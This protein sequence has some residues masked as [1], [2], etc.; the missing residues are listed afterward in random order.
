MR[1]ALQHTATL[2]GILK[3]EKGSMAT[4]N[5]GHGQICT[6]EGALT[7]PEQ[8]VVF[9]MRSV[10][11]CQNL[12]RERGDTV[13]AEHGRTAVDLESRSR[14]FPE[15]LPASDR[16]GNHST[17]TNQCDLSHDCGARG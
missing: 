7:S 16:K 3:P 13:M 9:T 15:A 8:R 1:P 10:S 11:R 5:L 17:A 14:P 4:F 12:C 6:M 2:G